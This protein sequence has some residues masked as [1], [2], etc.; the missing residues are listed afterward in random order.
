MKPHLLFS[1]SSSYLPIQAGHKTSILPFMFFNETFSIFLSPF[2]IFKAYLNDLNQINYS[3]AAVCF[4]LCWYSVIQ[5]HWSNLE[6]VYKRM[7]WVIII[8]S[9]SFNTF[10]NHLLQRVC[11]DTSASVIV[12]IL[13]H[14]LSIIMLQRCFQAWYYLEKHVHVLHDTYI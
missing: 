12:V 4:C 10:V 2:S 7:S 11:R 8:G 6:V 3:K 13:R 9:F 5:L 14:N 1:S